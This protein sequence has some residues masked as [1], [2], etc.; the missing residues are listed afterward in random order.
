[1]V[2]QGAGTEGV[3]GESIGAIAGW[4]QGDLLGLGQVYNP[5]HLGGQSRW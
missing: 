5:L 1:M 2:E 3:A 4:D